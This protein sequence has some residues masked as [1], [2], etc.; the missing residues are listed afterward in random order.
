MPELTQP[1]KVLLVDDETAFLE[2]LV[3]RLGKRG[4]EVDT[5]SSGEAALAFL[6]DHTVDVVVMDVR[7]PGLDGIE[8]LKRIKQTGETGGLV[9]IIMLTGHASVEVAIR[10]MELGAFDYLMKPVELS[11]L[12]YKIQDAC[13]KKRLQEQKIA[14]LRAAS[15]TAPS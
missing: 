3:K 11:E 5:A 8:T 14:A 15:G 4:L 12:V 9:E 6:Q 7:M 10:G 1:A 2:T 13:K